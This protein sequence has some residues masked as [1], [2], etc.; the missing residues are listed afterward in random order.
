M[1]AYWTPKQDTDISD[2]ED[3]A[4][5]SRASGWFA[6]T[7]GASTGSNSREW[8][9]TLA[10]SF[11]RD[12]DQPGLRARRALP[13]GWPMSGP[14]FDP[15]ARVTSRLRNVPQWV[16]QTGAAPGRFRDPGRRAAQR[17]PAGRGRGR[18]LLPV[19]PPSTAARGAPARPLPMSF[20]LDDPG[21]VRHRSDVGLQRSPG[22]RSLTGTSDTSPS[23]FEPGDVVFA[24]TDALAQDRCR[25]ICASRLSGNCSPASDSAGFAD[26]CRDLRATGAA[27]ERR[28]DPVPGAV[29]RDPGGAR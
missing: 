27:E 21:P 16:R 4:A 2:W 11:V 20:P 15:E 9:Y 26:L 25:G 5:Y 24:A 6:V 19:P 3:G 23:G 29:A 17:R 7:D 18:R 22:N 1:V 13:T 28:R 10:E 8:A 12:A 14:T